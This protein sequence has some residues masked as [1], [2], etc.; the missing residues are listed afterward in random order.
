[1]EIRP[2][3]TFMLTM[4]AMLMYF[5]FSNTGGCST[6]TSSCSSFQVCTYPLM[7]FFVNNVF[8]FQKN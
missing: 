6:T 1:M 3:N 4:A 2:L 5:N 7:Y 8:R